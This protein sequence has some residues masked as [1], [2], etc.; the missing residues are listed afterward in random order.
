MRVGGDHQSAGVDVTGLQPGELVEQDAW[1]DHHAV[2]DDVDDPGGEDAGGD[3]VQREVLA[4]RK[5]HGVPGVVTTLVADDPLDA[6]AEQVGG[7]ALTFVA[8][9]GTDQH[10]GRHV[11]L[12][13]NSGGQGSGSRSWCGCPAGHPRRW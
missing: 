1:V 9:L 8:P 4:V 11:K 12:Q 6:V 7:L 3:E 5:N 10:D 13:E 2:A